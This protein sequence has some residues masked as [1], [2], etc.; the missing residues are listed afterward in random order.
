VKEILPLALGRE[1][2]G[3]GISINVFA[4]GVFL[5]WSPIEWEVEAR[6]HKSCVLRLQALWSHCYDWVGWLSPRHT[7]EVLGYFEEFKEKDMHL[8]CGGR[9][10]YFTFGSQLLS[11]IWVRGLPEKKLAGVVIGC[12]QVPNPK[13]RDILTCH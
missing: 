4:L 12:F 3:F 13:N 7:T 8:K 5:V 1:L 6:E 10:L 2:S 11:A 9:V